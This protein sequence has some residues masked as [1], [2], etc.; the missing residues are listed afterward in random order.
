MG[1][2]QQQQQ[3]KTGFGFNM[4]G[5]QQ[6]NGFGF[7]NNKTGTGF[8]FNTNQGGGAGFGF[9][10]GGQQKNGFGGFNMNQQKTGKVC[11]E[12]FFKAVTVF[13]ASTWEEIW[14]VDFKWVRAVAV[15]LTSTRAEEDLDLVCIVRFL[16]STTAIKICGV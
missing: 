3:Q 14:E 11:M 4:N 1:G 8:G 6:G 2:Q 13:K 10:A 5:Q 7:N 12:C 9:N 16:K 15:A